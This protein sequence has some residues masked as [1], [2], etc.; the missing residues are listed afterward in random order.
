MIAL[1]RL[2]EI[3]ADL[4]RNLRD[5][6][7]NPVAWAL[8]G[9]WLFH[10]AL[11][12]A[13]LRMDDYPLLWDQGHTYRITLKNYFY[14][15]HCHVPLIDSD[16][17][18]GKVAGLHKSHPVLL[19][20]ISWPVAVPIALIHPLFSSHR[21]PPLVY[22]L[23]SLPQLVFGADRDVAALGNCALSFAALIAGAYMLGK[24]L[25]DRQTGVFAAF[26]A[27]SYPCMFGLPR[28]HMLDTALAGMSAVALACL[29]DAGDF[30]DGRASKRFGIAG[31]IAMLTKFASAI[32]LALPCAFAFWVH[33]VKRHNEYG[34]RDRFR[35]L[36]KSAGWAAGISA[37]FYVPFLPGIVKAYLA[38]AANTETEWKS[39]PRFSWQGLNYYF[40]E[41]FNTQ[42]GFILALISLTGL[43]IFM[44]RGKGKRALVGLGILGMYIAGVL[45][46]LKISRYTIAWM[47]L[48]A[49]CAAAGIMNLRSRFLRVAMVGFTVVAGA[50]QCFVFSFDFYPAGWPQ[51]LALPRP[52]ERV[53]FFIRP[54]SM[55]QTPEPDRWRSADVVTALRN[56][57]QGMT[58]KV[59]TVCLFNVPE[60]VT[61]LNY[62]TILEAMDYRYCFAPSTLDFTSSRDNPGLSE[63]APFVLVKTGGT[64]GIIYDEEIFKQHTEDFLRRAE[65]VK[66]P[67]GEDGGKPRPE[68]LA[69]WSLP[70]GSELKLYRN[71]GISP[72]GE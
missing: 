54:M 32:I 33:F 52:F 22:I 9:I 42:A 37:V 17:V 51:A 14:L 26:V 13:W 58:G 23:S 3:A 27:S 28:V 43:L 68:L 11:S 31:G 66:S 19:G 46:V 36:L 34:V 64:L 41:F 63:I 29:I 72:K 62:R 4:A 5:N 65:G 67:A 2:S 39:A 69:M 70:D 24:R 47:P 40:I 71:P 53:Y 20:M 21:H 25:L 35:N 8:L 56:N 61:P 6:R 38:V 18:M 59:K 1:K 60:I 16:A 15:S 12:A 48:I 44:F 45:V 10:V 57:S 7:R 50:V 30:S 55:T 49:A